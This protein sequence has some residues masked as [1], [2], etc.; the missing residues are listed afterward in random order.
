MG[1]RRLK[2]KTPFDTSSLEGPPEPLVFY[3][4]ECLGKGVG[5]ALQQAGADVRLPE[6]FVARG[7]RDEEWLARIGRQKWIVLT[8]DKNIRLHRYEREALIRAGVKAF[9]LTSGNLTGA[10]MAQ[11]FVRNL[12]KM[13]RLVRET[14]HAFIAKVTR[15]D[16]V[17]LYERMG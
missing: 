14:D 7:T 1:A 17:M 9:V 2:S 11:V 15:A 5:E 10:E 3:I 16:V 13:Q 12:V 8:K 6:G 4:D